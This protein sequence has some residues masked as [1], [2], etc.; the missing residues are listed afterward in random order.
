MVTIIKEEALPEF[1]RIITYGS[2]VTNPK[3][4]KVRYY[5]L[6][7]TIWHALLNFDEINPQIRILQYVIMPDHVHVLL[8]ITHE[9]ERPLGDYIAV[10]KRKIFKDALAQ[11]FIDKTFPRI[12]Q[13]G[14]NDQ[15]LRYSRNLQTLFD[16][17]RENPY[18]L[19]IR[20]VHSEFFSKILNSKIL[21]IDCCLY[22]NLALLE[23]PFIYPVVIHRKDSA[24]ELEKKKEIWRYV[25]KNGGVLVG[26][27]IS[28][29]ENKIFKGAAKYGGHIILISNKTFEKRE[30]STGK[31]FD[32][33]EK[34]QLLIISPKME[35]SKM[36]PVASQ[37]QKISRAECLFMNAFA[38]KLAA[39][40]GR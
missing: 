38:E 26:A 21:D 30:K 1:S 28:E 39:K 16:Y 35:F 14:F 6:G 12:F 24:S 2:E 13:V 37:K 3:E 32:L 29:G 34:G 5:N 27:F 11:G 8:E 22:G 25:L 31:L 7:F 40:A 17:I 10:F 33:C 36:N 4:V 23:N 20:R 19:W 18:R 15:F 9:M